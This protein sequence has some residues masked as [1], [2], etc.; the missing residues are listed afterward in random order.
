MLVGF[1]GFG[2]YLGLT[3]ALLHATGARAPGL[4]AV[5]AAPVSALAVLGATIT[6]GIPV[7][8]WH[9]AAGFAFPTVCFLMV[10][11]ATYKSLSL[12]IL[13]D[14]SNREGGR[15]AYGAILDRYI[16]KESYANRL[17]VMETSGF[18]TCLD[19][20]YALTPRGAWLAAR[21]RAVQRFF[22]IGASG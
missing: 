2:L 15:D 5:L 7:Q 19:G 12:R 20:R 8:F 17:Q 13:L 3:L 10:F 9:F 22:A 6:A 16:A 18:T 21:V 11:G 14:L 4:T 1:A